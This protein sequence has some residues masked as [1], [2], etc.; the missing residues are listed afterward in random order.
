MRPT[1]VFEP[2]GP[3]STSCPS[4]RAQKSLTTPEQ[5]IASTRARS[6]RGGTVLQ[7]GRGALGG[8][9][10]HNK[11]LVPVSR[12]SGRRVSG[13]GSPHRAAVGFQRDPVKD[14]RARALA[15]D[16]IRDET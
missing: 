9:A 6:A 13:A 8:S 1:G 11:A 10:P 7:T 14:F 15:L 5:P 3:T 2:G 12:V 16:T 4:A